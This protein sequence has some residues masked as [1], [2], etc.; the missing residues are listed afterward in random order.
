[1]YNPTKQELE[2]AAAVRHVAQCDRNIRNQLAVIGELERDG[3]DTAGAREVLRGFDEVRRLY[4][5]DRDRLR[6]ELGR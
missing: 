2:F 1:M 5:K 3:H 4:A 6:K